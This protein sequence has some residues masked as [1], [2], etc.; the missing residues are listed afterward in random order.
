[1]ADLSDGM[2]NF[3]LDRGV[4]DNFFVQTIKLLSNVHIAV[5]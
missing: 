4:L 3:E 1:M 2:S 5:I